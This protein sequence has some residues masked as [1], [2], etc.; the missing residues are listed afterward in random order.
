MKCRLFAG[1]APDVGYNNSEKEVRDLSETYRKRMGWIDLIRLQSLRSNP[2][3]F[4]FR[5]IPIDPTVMSN[6]KTRGVT[7]QLT[8]SDDI[9]QN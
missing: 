5:Q 2:S 4:Y 3:G 7:M 8:V 1:G 6:M 9:C